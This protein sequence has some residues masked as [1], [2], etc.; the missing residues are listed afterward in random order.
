MYLAV[1]AGGCCPTG[2][3]SSHPLPSLAQSPR[4]SSESLITM[5]PTQPGPL[6]WQ[7]ASW[8]PQGWHHCFWGQLAGRRGEVGTGHAGA[9]AGWEVACLFLP[10]PQSP[11]GSTACR[12]HTDE[13]LGAPT[14]AEV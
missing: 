3:A 1:G 8:H 11:T 9:V 6:A 5:V 14:G 7:Q 4:R 2:L 13:G 10:P 12:P